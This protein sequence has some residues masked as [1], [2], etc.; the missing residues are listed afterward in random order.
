[1]LYS[2]IKIPIR[3]ALKIFCRKT[4]VS[5]ADSIPKQ[6][7]VLIV[8]NHPN[9][10][11]DAIIIGSIFS[12]PVHF[13]ARGDAFRKPWHNRLLRL[14]HMIPV[15]RLSEGK[16]NL[17]LNET[18]FRRSSG[19]LSQNGV[20]LIFVEGISVNKHELQPFK[21]GAARIALESSGDE[22]LQ[23]L[24]LAIAYDSFERFGK[25]VNIN[26]AKPLLA[27]SLF[28]FE[29]E[30]KNIRHFNDVLYKE[31]ER[32]IEI[33]SD[34]SKQSFTE[35]LLLLFPGIIGYCLHFPFYFPIRS[36]IRKKTKGS[37]FYDSVLFGVLLILYPLYVLLICWLIH[38]LAIPFF[39]IVLIFFLCPVLAW[40]AVQWRRTG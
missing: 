3:L 37:I 12:R 16:E 8:A 15:Y 9:S 39:I 4:V 36:L 34:R 18:A 40:S 13:L 28:P 29:E 24:P 5:G 23:I 10:F 2:L 19:I 32:R 17:H 25:Q 7:P 20:V 22:N 21:K 27:K 26:I 1:L 33:S 6:G 14:L 31:I 11:L 30:A 35:K 38:F